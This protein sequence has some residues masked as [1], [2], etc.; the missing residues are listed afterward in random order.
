MMHAPR[1][2]PNSRASRT[3]LGNSRGFTLI[4]MLVVVAVGIIM[5]AITIP[6]VSSSV[7][8]YRVSSAV[9][10]LTWA[11]NSVRYQALEEGYPFQVVFSSSA[12]TYL[13]QS[14]PT[15]NG[16]YSN[17]DP[18]ANASVPFSSYPVVLSADTTL[19]FKPNGYVTPVTGTLIFT[20]TYQGICQ[21]LSVTNY[22][23]V[24]ITPSHPQPT[25]P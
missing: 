4:E 5:T 8:S 24:S 12:N 21:K 3:L 15:N 17:V 10:S 23:N 6:A 22:G 1:N 14:S 25:C 20:V 16:T 2:N 11:I 18:S 13:I 19:N 7:R 9:S